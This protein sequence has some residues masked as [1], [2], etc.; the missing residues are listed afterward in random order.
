MW[1]SYYLQNEAKTCMQA[2]GKT[3]LKA[4]LRDH[5]EVLIESKSLTDRFW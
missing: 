3:I 5:G 1:R 4:H 2:M